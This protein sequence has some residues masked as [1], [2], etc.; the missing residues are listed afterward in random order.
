[1]LPD[2]LIEKAEKKAEKTEPLLTTDKPDTPA[3]PAK[4]PATWLTYHL[5][6]PVT[7]ATGDP[8]CIFFWKGRY[9]LHYII[10]DKAGICLLCR[11][12][13]QGSSLHEIF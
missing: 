1:M 9:H 6:H 13:R 11:V 3:M 12:G 10:E 5:A 4:P 8:N 2:D 7:T